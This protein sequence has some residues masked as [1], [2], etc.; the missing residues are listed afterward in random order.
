MYGRAGPFWRTV[1][2]AVID[3]HE[4][5]LQVG[6]PKIWLASLFS[7]AVQGPYG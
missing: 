4:V 1:S 3:R 6:L 7:I 5:V 2:V